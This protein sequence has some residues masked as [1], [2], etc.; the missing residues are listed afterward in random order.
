MRHTRVGTESTG[1]RNRRRDVF[2][3]VLNHQPHSGQFSELDTCVLLLNPINSPVNL[4]PF[5]SWL[6]KNLPELMNLPRMSWEIILNSNFI[7]SKIF[8]RK[9]IDVCSLTSNAILVLLKQSRK[10]PIQH[11]DGSRWRRHFLRGQWKRKLKA[12]ISFNRQWL[13]MCSFKNDFPS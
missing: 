5:P 3:K 2:T 4:V 6:T 11:S 13:H 8:R 10:R 1:R 9:C 7:P 12:V